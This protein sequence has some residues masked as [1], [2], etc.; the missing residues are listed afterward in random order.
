MLVTLLRALTILI[1]L[2]LKIAYEDKFTPIIP[3]FQAF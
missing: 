2:I 3:I 1:N